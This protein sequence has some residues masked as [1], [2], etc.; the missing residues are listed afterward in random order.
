VELTE[1]EPG[2]AFYLC[3]PAPNG[4]E[5]LVQHLP[6]SLES[7]L[8]NPRLVGIAG[9]LIVVTAEHDE[10]PPLINPLGG[11]SG[12]EENGSDDAIAS[13]N[14]A[15]LIQDATDPP[16]VI[17][18]AWS[19]DK[20]RTWQAAKLPGQKPEINYV[21]VFPAIVTHD[22][23]VTLI[24]TISPLGRLIAPEDVEGQM[25]QEEFDQLVEQQLSSAG[26][27]IFQGFS[28][29]LDPDP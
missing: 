10:R 12:D 3:Y 14:S 18:L 21:R 8:S 29:Q 28:I 13:M 2:E 23:T 26:D 15:M 25:T 24:I 9:E 22:G 4:D 20:G 17:Y 27:D 16:S 5:V 7:E 19:R 11:S 1:K 6:F